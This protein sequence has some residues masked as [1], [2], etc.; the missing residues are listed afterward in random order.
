MNLFAE[1]DEGTML[2]WK[3]QSVYNNCCIGNDGLLFVTILP[4]RFVGNLSNLHLEREFYSVAF[5]VWGPLIGITRTMIILCVSTNYILLLE[6]Q[7][8]CGCV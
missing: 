4:Y 1:F 3:S 6:G 8:S 2:A 7:Q 5:L